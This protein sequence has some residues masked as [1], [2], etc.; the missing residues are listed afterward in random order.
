MRGAQSTW[1]VRGELA[2]MLAPITCQQLVQYSHYAD[3]SEL[4][5]NDAMRLQDGPIDSMSTT[6]TCL[7]RICR[8][9]SPRRCRRARP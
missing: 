1:S 7:Q 8:L 9:R 6:I 4:R 3:E 2:A 5:V